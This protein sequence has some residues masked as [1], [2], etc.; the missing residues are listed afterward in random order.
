MRNSRI[1]RSET[2]SGWRH[3]EHGL[4]Q[5]LQVRDWPVALG[6]SE[7]RPRE[8]DVYT[9]FTWLYCRP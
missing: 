2:L 1:Y 6:Y 7:W 9:V 5:C 4:S 3:F 8:D